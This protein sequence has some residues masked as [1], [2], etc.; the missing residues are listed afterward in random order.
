M[1][2]WMK[3]NVAVDDDVCTVHHQHVGKVSLMN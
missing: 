3:S 1:K 2:V